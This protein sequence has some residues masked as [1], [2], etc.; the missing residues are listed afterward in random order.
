MFDRLLRRLSAFI[1]DSMLATPR[2]HMSWF[3]SAW[4]VKALA[5]GFI[6][7]SFAAQRDYLPLIGL[8]L[9]IPAAFVDEW[10]RV[11]A[12]SE[13]REGTPRGELIFFNTF[14][15]SMQVALATIAYVVSTATDG[16]MFGVL[17]VCYVGL[18]VVIALVVMRAEHPTA[19]QIRENATEVTRRAGGPEHRE[20]TGKQVTCVI[21]NHVKRS[22]G[23][24]EQP[25]SQTPEDRAEA[26]ARDLADR[27]LAVTARAVRE[28][29][30]VRMTVASEVA[31][32]WRGRAG[33]KWRGRG[34]CRARRCAG[35]SRCDL[36]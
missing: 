21:R 29:A 6:G 18:A 36:G 17:L 14:D 10:A 13:S 32:A 5:A 27:G 34:A 35:P 7:W 12:A 33:R 16:V 2:R 9:F 3:L 22:R 8:A 30:K 31:R 25:E 1:I 11:K 28:A 19:N 20:V 4:I 15:Q 24:I 26:A 23:M